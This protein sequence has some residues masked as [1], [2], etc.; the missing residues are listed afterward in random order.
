MEYKMNDRS[1]RVLKAL[2]VCNAQHNLFPEQEELL[3]SQFGEDSWELLPIPAE[4]WDLLYMKDRVRYLAEW[5]HGVRTTENTPMF[6]NSTPPIAVGETF[7]LVFASPV[8]GLMALWAREMA[9]MDGAANM[10]A[11]HNDCRVSK[12]VPDGKGGVRLI[13]TVAPT[14]WV[15]V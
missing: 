11:F 13:K 2:V 7:T 10:S 9:T 6:E 8:P 12:E 3:S 14:G 4:G 15:L 5:A 1:P